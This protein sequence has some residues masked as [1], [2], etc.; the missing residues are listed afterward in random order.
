MNHKENNPWNEIPLQDYENHMSHN[1]VGQ[2]SV[3]N[4]LTKK[5]LNSI[6]PQTCVFLG[7][8]GV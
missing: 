7:V 5:Y 6:K 8:A 4:S 3:L 1:S 2:L